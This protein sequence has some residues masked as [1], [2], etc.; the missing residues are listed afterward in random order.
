[1]EKGDFVVWHCHKWQRQRGFAKEL[2]QIN[3]KVV[4]ETG[5]LAIILN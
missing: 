1:M 5:T 4:C 2:V 3:V